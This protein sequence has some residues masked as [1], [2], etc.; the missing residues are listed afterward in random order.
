MTQRTPAAGPTLA[1]LGVVLA[2]GAC[3]I[4]PAYVPANT[5]VVADPDVA[6]ADFVALAN[7]SR[8]EAG[9]GT[10]EWRD[11]VARVAQAHSEDMRE[12]GYFEHVEPSG[13]T[14]LGRI[15]DAGIPISGVAENIAQG[16]LDGAG[17]L[18]LWLDSPG[19][20]R[21]LLDCG[22]THHGVG[23]AGTYWTHV[24]IRP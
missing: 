14:P 4:Q 2:L 15:R 16:N 8:L 19:H 22:Y 6:I 12:R 10:L 9:C 24:L 7:R 11:D 13:R 18:R 23:L 20:R 17:V 5:P 21:N 1:M 3:V